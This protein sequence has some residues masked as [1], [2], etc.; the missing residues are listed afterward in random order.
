MTFGTAAP[1]AAVTDDAHESAHW[2]AVDR[3][4]DGSITDTGL[5]H[6]MHDLFEGIQV[7]RRV[8]VKFDIADVT[9]VGKRMV[10]GFQ[11]NLLESGNLV[12]HRNVERVGVVVAVGHA[13]DNTELL[14]VHTHET[15]G[16]AFGRRSEQAEV[17]AETFGFLVA[18]FAHV[19]DNLEAELLG[20]F[21]F[22]VV[23][24]RE[25]HQRFG[26]ADKADRK[27]TVLD[28]FAHGVF[29]AELVG[30]DPHALS[31]KEREVLDLA[32]ALDGKAFHELVAHQLKHAVEF[33]E[34][35]IHGLHLDGDTR[36]V[37]RRKAQ[38]ATA[39]ADFAGRIVVVTDH[40]GTAAHVGN[41]GFR[42]ARLVVLQVVRGILEAEVREQ[43]LL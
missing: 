29:P 42:V 25:H 43:A 15:T 33:L 9:S 2:V 17:E 20:F 21:G 14:L 16:K 4:V 34:E 28:D 31:H 1:R 36:K 22:A 26:E 23:L 10:R 8:A 27:R 11:R 38:V 7:L 32:T 3:V 30:I 19:A 6:V 13:R 37:D 5:R 24:A 12:V 39:E 18:E 41:F 40:A 35:Q